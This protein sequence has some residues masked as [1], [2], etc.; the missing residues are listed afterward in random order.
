MDS[1]A[2]A[3]SNRSDR[4]V[5]WNRRHALVVLAAVVPALAFS[6][7][8][9]VSAFAAASFAALIRDHDALR[10]PPAS[11][12]GANWVTTARLAGT[13]ALPGFAAIGP[14]AVAACAVLLFALDGV[15]GWLARRAGLAS[16]FGEYFDKETDAL[17]MLVLCL[18]LHDAGRFG[19]W[20]LLPGLLRY[21]FVVFL[22]IA[23]PPEAKERRNALGR[24]IF[25]GTTCALIASF[26]PFRALYAPS[27]AAMTVLLVASFAAAVVDLYRPVRERP[28]RPA[29]SRLA[30]RVV[31][32]PDDV[33]VFFDSLANEYHDCHGD[34]EHALRERLA[35][36]RRLLPE[37][38]SLLVEIGCGN[39]MHLFGLAPLFDAS[40][41]ID[42]SPRMVAAAEAQRS[43]HGAGA[44][45]R[46]AVDRAQRL[47]S[48][49]DESA[50]VVLCVGAFEH[51]I[52]QP[53]VLA[54][55]A[56]ALRP[57]GAFVCLSPNGGYFWYTCL[58][59]W[60][61]LETRH[62]STDRFVPPGQWPALL[63]Y[64]GLQ[65]DA[66]GY[67]RFVP[68][69]DMPRWAARTMRALDRIGALLHAG[70]LRGGCYVKAVKPGVPGSA[71]ARREGATL[72]RS[73]W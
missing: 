14:L 73:S 44:R 53:A 35:L 12:G 5:D 40:I 22:M 38:R 67:W 2:Q 42:G 28:D 64:A 21:G 16:E 59:P 3:L 25:F 29:A 43:Q 46:L 57:G 71:S 48:V 52:D 20:I 32:H 24:W 7:A 13:L 10:L 65:T 55:V 62:L 41:G 47:S 31:T 58:A 18:L 26:T 17:L 50:D 30:T 11:F 15:D 66:I 1:V 6:S 45:V 9:W 63:A 23:R 27:M 60:L 49:A 69:G 19:G 39:G 36:I 54:E 70:A 68:A 37:R 33:F 34:A 56:R 61:G 4:L 51:M 8:W 72:S